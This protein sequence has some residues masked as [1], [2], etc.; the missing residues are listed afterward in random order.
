MATKPVGSRSR[1]LYSRDDRRVPGWRPVH[2]AMRS[3]HVFVGDAR[4]A[5][6]RDT[7]LPSVIV[8]A[9]LD[10]MT[11]RGDQIHAWM[12]ELPTAVHTALLGGA[13][14]TYLGDAPHVGAGHTGVACC[15]TICRVRGTTVAVMHYCHPER[16]RA[17]SAL[18]RDRSVRE[19]EGEYQP[20]WS[21]FAWKLCHL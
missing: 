7:A 11:R 8:R 21:R 4:L 12:W 9:C 3:S 17:A 20:A 16:A 5:T 18:L 2:C 14:R 13:L 19:A 1:M 15:G 6:I 10:A